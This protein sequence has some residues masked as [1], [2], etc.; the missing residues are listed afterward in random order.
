[1]KDFRLVM[2]LQN[3]MSIVIKILAC[4]GLI[5]LSFVSVFASNLSCTNHN[6]L[7]IV[8]INGVNTKEEDANNTAKNIRD[9]L[10]NPSIMEKVNSSKQIE[11]GYI[12]N[13]SRGLYNDL[14]ELRNQVFYTL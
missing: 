7:H 3:H 6:G 12:Y 2:Y 11:V 1:M 4:Y 14:L 5:Y 13:E 9:L 8:Y 10:K